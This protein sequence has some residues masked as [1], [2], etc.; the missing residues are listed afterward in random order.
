[1]ALDTFW[2]TTE[3]QILRFCTFF[4]SAFSVLGSFF[5]IY[6]F[7]FLSPARR[8]NLITRFVFYLSGC[9]FILS[10]CWIVSVPL[11]RF[12]TTCEV[13]APL[14]LYFFIGAFCWTAFIATEVLY[15]FTHTSVGRFGEMV[16]P[17]SSGIPEVC[18]HLIAWILPAILTFFPAWF[19][20]MGDGIWNCWFLEADDPW[21]YLFICMVSI[22]IVYCMVAYCIVWYKY[23]QRLEEIG[24]LTESED[25]KATKLQFRITGYLI[26]FLVVWI[27][28]VAVQILGA[29]DLDPSMPFFVVTVIGSLLLPFNGFLDSLVYG[30]NRQLL[31]EL[32]VH[33]YRN[34][35]CFGWGRGGGHEALK[36][37]RLCFYSCFC[38]SCEYSEYDEVTGVNEDDTDRDDVDYSSTVYTD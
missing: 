27:P 30:W 22:T 29:I 3:V 19:R 10:V 38:K 36:E 37:K 25:V 5:I 17:A 24:M 14:K 31:E 35:W 1:M 20:R 18:Y 21:N 33:C 6:C 7:I 32:R 28:G 26:S 13:L 23:R 12:T 2:T 15:C 8:Q 34:C 11:E 4:S 16:V 9:H